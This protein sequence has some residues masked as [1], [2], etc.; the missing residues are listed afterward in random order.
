LL[1]AVPGSRLLVVCPEGQARERTR[2]HFTTNGIAPERLDFIAPRPWA[3]YSRLF[4]RIDVA[5]DAYPCNGMTTTCHALW[6]GVPV[7][8]LMGANAESRAGS[9]L[10][11]TIGL[12]EW[13]ARSEE[14]YIRIAAELA[15][16]LPRL[17]E[18]RAVLRTRMEASP[19]MDAPR[20]A[21]H[22]EAA[23]RTMWQRWCLQNPSPNR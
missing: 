19:L 21:R 12:P 8:T 4:E 7:V 1:G 11:H 2:A 9:S 15:S 20:F 16:D 3:E 14:E 18:L 23:C 22:F 5:L 17:A 6:M 13:V 10:L